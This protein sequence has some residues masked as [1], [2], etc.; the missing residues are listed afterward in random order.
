MEKI[1]KLKERT[2]GRYRRL[3]EEGVGHEGH[4]G[5]RR[6]AEPDSERSQKPPVLP[7]PHAVPTS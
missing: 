6:E 3:E 2:E 1:Y 7:L 5:S 4:D